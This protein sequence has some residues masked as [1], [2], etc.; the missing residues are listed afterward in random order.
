MD[1][2]SS[3]VLHL[4]VVSV[5]VPSDAVSCTLSPTHIVVRPLILGT[6]GGRTTT[7]C[8]VSSEQPFR[9]KTVT[10]YSVVTVGATNISL[11]VCPSMF[12]R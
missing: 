8:V 5:L 12:Q 10:L 7:V 2:V 11:D 6:G 9:L 4:E 3:P 1:C